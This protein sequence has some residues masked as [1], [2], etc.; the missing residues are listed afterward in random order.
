MAVIKIL[1]RHDPSYANL[2]RY[3]L[4]PHKNQTPQ[5]FTHNLR[6]DTLKDWTKEFLKNESYRAHIRKDQIYLTHEIIS[7]SNRDTNN[8]T[9]EILNDLAHAYIQLRG[10]QGI[11]VGAVHRD[12]DHL[13]FHYCVSGTALY[14]G[15]AMRLSREKLQSLKVSFQKYYKQKYPQIEHSGCEHGTDKPYEPHARGYMK[16]RLE[17]K[18]HIEKSVQD[19]FK[20]ATTQQT[21]LTLLQKQ[22]LHH[23][24]RN[25]RPEGIVTPDG[26]KFRFSRFG[27]AL[28][29]LPNNTRTTIKALSDIR[30]LR[31]EH[32][33]DISLER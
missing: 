4:K 17:Q 1:S 22:D 14:T 2:I 8:I 24:E 20:K 23:Y 5:V 13:H 9:P 3:I 7:F 25:G 32:E 19:S 16:K 18:A 27:I 33:N 10:P 30:T 12:K 28:D 29:T 26:I 21:F 15:K 11:F 31:Q 6:T